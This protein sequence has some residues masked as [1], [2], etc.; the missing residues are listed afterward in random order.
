MLIFVISGNTEKAD[1]MKFSICGTKK[2]SVHCVNHILVSTPGA[3]KLTK[4]KIVCVILIKVA[5]L[6][7][8][9]N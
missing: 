1:V 3:Q 2:I 7:E 8:V 4:Q 6:S 5:L 9:I